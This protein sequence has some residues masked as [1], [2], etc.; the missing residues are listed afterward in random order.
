MHQ[1]KLN[2]TNIALLKNE[3]KKNLIQNLLPSF[4]P[5][6]NVLEDVR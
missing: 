3:Q 4:K 5:A 1:A 6:Q 2:N